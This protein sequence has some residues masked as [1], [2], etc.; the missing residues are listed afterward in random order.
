M[1]LTGSRRTMWPTQCKV[2]HELVE[3]GNSD[4]GMNSM[5][6]GEM[7]KRIVI[8]EDHPD[9]Q[10]MYNAALRKI[11]AV[12]VV[13]QMMTAEEAIR[14]VPELLP[15]LALVDISLPGMSGLKLTTHLKQDNPDIKV[16]VVTAHDRE[17]FFDQAIKSGADGLI[18]KGD[19][20]ELRRAVMRLLQI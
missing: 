4:D 7:T 15:D 8:V 19:V 17:S 2:G 11:S 16:L 6:F 12:E 5:G 18:A 20:Q 9:M 3:F 13:A 1:L 10:L 14:R